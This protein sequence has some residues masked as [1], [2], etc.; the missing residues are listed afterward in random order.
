MRR[1]IL[2]L[3][4]VGLLAM[5][6][7]W[8]VR[9]DRPIQDVAFA[10]FATD[11]TPRRIVAFGTSLTAGNAWPDRLGVALTRCFEHPVTV[12][13]VATAG[14]GSAWGLAAVPDVVALAPDVVLIEFTINDADIRDG[15]SV[16][17]SRVQHQALF[18]QLK[19]NLPDARLVVMTMSPARG[20]RAWLRPRL[21]R[22]V[23]Q[24]VDLAATQDIAII[25]FT[26]RWQAVEW[27]ALLP[28]GLHPTDAA[29][30][31]IMDGVLIASFANA[32][33]RQC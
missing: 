12:S 3:G 6:G 22:Y 8:M 28:D 20:L 5:A 1:I 32:A 9:N 19:Q 14:A 7:A 15:V 25:D 26:P 11:E 31:R 24:V 30:A 33:G 2:G 16:A 23:A 21:A 13:R 4:C 10:P 27:R 18:D 17:Q 29:T